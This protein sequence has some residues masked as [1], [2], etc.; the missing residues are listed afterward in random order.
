MKCAQNA[1][2]AQYSPHYKM[3]AV[4]Q[5]SVLGVQASSTASV[6]E[7]AEKHS[8]GLLV[9]IDAISA[10]FRGARAAVTFLDAHSDEQSS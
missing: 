5:Q 10:S 8:M 2:S 1:D 6:G 9:G 3:G 7:E 4:Q